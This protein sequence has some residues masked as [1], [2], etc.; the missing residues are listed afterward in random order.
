MSFA[1]HVR[2]AAH[3]TVGNRIHLSAIGRMSGSRI[4]VLR[5]N[6]EAVQPSPAS[7]AFGVIDAIDG[8]LLTVSMQQR[9]DGEHERGADHNGGDGDGDGD[10]GDHGHH[11][12]GD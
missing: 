1:L 7:L 5:H 10:D 12:G 2:T 8:N 4:A 3:H 9:D 11:G 6:A